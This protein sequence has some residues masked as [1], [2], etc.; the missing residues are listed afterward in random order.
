MDKLKGKKIVNLYH[1]SAYGKET[2]PVLDVQAKKYGFQVTHIAVP[3]PGNEQQSQW[4]QVRQIRPDWVILR[5][6]GVMNPT[7]LKAAAK[8]GFPRTKILGVW[9]SGAEEDVIPAGDAAKGYIA[10]GFNAPGSN[11]P[12][13]R[14]IQKHVYAKGQGELEDNSRLGSIYYNRGVLWAILTTEAVRTA[15]GRFGRG[16]PMTGEQVRWG[17]ENL[18]IDDKRLKEL[19]A[20]GFMQPLKL[21]CADHEGGGQ[22]KFQQWDGRQWKVITDWI[23]SDQKL[24]RPM[25]EASAAQYAKEKGITP[26][27]CS[28]EK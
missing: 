13:L 16:Q 22:V 7:A 5:G 20:V 3:H 2:I 17:L 11:F 1:D 9:W 12:V 28:K 6:W 26:R 18:N 14:D 4:L 21:S 23:P 10:A 27:D 24:V 19:G 25:I 15:Q 8:V